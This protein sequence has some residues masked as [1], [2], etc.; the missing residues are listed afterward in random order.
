MTAIRVATGQDAPHVHRLIEQL[1]APQTVDFERFSRKYR[2]NLANPS[3]TYLI[4]EAEGAVCAFGSMQFTAPLHHDGPVAEIV[5]LVVEESSRGAGVGAAM[6]EAMAAQARARGCCVLELSTGRMRERA[7]RF[8]ENQ[9]FRLTHWRFT[10][11]LSE[12]T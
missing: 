10:M 4:A 9:G 7:H 3:I 5:E 2:S 11:A 8:Y 1:E 6:V 12:H